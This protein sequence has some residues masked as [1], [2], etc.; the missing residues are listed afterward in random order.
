MYYKSNHERCWLHLIDLYLP[1]VANRCQPVLISVEGE[2][3][4]DWLSKARKARLAGTVPRHL[5]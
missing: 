1:P 5:G 3:H 2:C 4:A